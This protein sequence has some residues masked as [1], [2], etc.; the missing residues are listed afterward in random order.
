METVIIEA[1]GKK[2][3]ALLSVLSV[4]DIPFKK[5]KSAIRGKISSEVMFPNKETIRAM[6]EL[7]EGKG[8]KFNSV[9]ELFKSI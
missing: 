3:K 2:L 1:E 9:D 8:V 4:L 5:E 7:K 6:K